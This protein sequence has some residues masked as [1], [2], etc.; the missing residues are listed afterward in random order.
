[1]APVRDGAGTLHLA[2]NDPS[3]HTSVETARRL[4]R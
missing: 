2:V 3:D 1:M 4:G